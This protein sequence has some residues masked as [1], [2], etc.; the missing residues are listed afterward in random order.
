MNLKIKVLISLED[1]INFLEVIDKMLKNILMITITNFV[2]HIRTQNGRYL[3][4]LRRTYKDFKNLYNY[5]TKD[6][7]IKADG[8]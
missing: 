5:I 6:L 2:L 4:R 1:L 7:R 3:K 8:I